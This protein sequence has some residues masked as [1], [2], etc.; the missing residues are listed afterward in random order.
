MSSLSGPLPLDSA[1]WSELSHA[2]G[3]ASDLPDLL[4]QI[5]RM[6][7]ISFEDKGGPFSQLISAVY[8]Q[9]D[10]TSAALAAAPHLLRTA[11]SKALPSR[12][13]LL[14][15]MGWIESVRTQE[16]SERIGPLYETYRQCMSEALSECIHILQL[17]DLDPVDLRYL[18]GAVAAFKGK[19][20]LAARVF[21]LDEL[22]AH[23][24]EQT[25]E[26]DTPPTRL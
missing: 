13:N 8:H 22:Y 20:F 2:Y 4:S 7:E 5:D 9:G 6:K 1:R 23:Y 16:C 26:D 18:L 24:L 10:A 3:P 17:D 12:I 15:V 14:I 19:Q 25:S 11:Q 21:Q